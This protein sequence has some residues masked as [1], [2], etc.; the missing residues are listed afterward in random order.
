MI[1]K[2][3]IWR[4]HFLTGFI[5]FDDLNLKFNIIKFNEI[6]LL[7]TAQQPSNQYL[8]EL[9]TLITDVL[10][11][12]KNNQQ[13]TTNDRILGI[14]HGGKQAL[15]VF[16]CLFQGKKIAVK[17][18]KPIITHLIVHTVAVSYLMKHLD[19]FNN[20]FPDQ[21]INLSFPLTIALG[22]PISSNYVHPISILVQEW[23]EDS[24]EIHKVY[25]REHVNIIRA[26]IRKLTVDWGFMVD[27]MSKNWLVVKHN[28]KITYVDLILFNPT[29]NILEKIK[30]WTNKLE[31]IF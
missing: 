17:I 14:H 24:D 8:Q 5:N 15:I 28:R 7:L 11:L 29:G 16:E 23:I 3:F 30:D 19:D 4:L 20:F 22:L 2:I 1:N 13:E 9:N 21:Q 12:Y 26:I 6:N 31:Y 10:S 18:Y 27:I 25:P